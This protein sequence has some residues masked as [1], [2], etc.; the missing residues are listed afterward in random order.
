[1]KKH[2]SIIISLISGLLLC[3]LSC[4]KLVIIQEPI[5]TITTGEVFQTK[6]AAISAI[7]GIYANMT[8]S[9][10]YNGT[11]AAGAA[12]VNCGMSADEL[13]FFGGTNT[14]ET[15]QLLSSDYGVFSPF[16]SKPYFSIYQANATIDGLNSSATLDAQTKSQLTAEARFLRAFNHFYLVNLYGDVPLVTTTSYAINSL[17]GRTPEAQVYAQVITDLLEAQKNLPEDYS[18]DSGDRIRANKWVATAMLSR[19]YLYQSHWADAEAQATLVINNTG[20]FNLVTDLNSVFLKNSSEAIWQ[21]KPIDPN[22]FSTYEAKQ[23]IPPDPST[24]SACTMTN[25]LLT[26]FET[27]DARRRFW[28]DSL[29]FSGITYYYPYKYKVYKTT[30]D[31]IT[32]YN[33]VLRLAEQYLIRA[34]ARA[35]QNNLEGCVGDLNVIRTRAGLANLPVPSTQAEALLEIAQERRIEL[36]AENG[37]RWLD[38]KRTGQ[39]DIVLGPLKATWRPAAKLYPIYL[40]ELQTDPNLTQNPDY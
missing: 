9:D 25:Q 21:L 38:L 28:I 18:A 26:S 1:M 17:I 4:K 40:M 34:E 20:L 13:N 29:I 5:N 27:G 36:F 7:N 19:V 22:S 24:N 31:N 14:F 37:H 11:V 30:S 2:K 10:S 12:T 33:M 39:A 8:P 23:F 35:E 16:W 3:C 6:S 15:N 32:E